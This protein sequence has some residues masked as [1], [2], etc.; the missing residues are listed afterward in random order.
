MWFF[1]PDLKQEALNNAPYIFPYFFDLK[2]I[3]LEWHGI[4]LT[5]STVEGPKLKMWAFCYFKAKDEILGLIN[6]WTY[7]KQFTEKLFCCFRRDDPDSTTIRFSLFS[8]ENL[9]PLEN[10]E[11]SAKEMKTNNLPWV[12]KGIYSEIS[13]SLEMEVGTNYFIFPEEYKQIDELSLFAAKEGIYP[14]QSPTAY[15]NNYVLVILKPKKDEVE[16]S[17]KIGL[18]SRALTL[19]MFGQ[20]ESPEAEETTNFTA[21]ELE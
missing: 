14:D 6:F 9:L 19:A 18:I 20:R 13:L 17:H 1:K 4:R 12:F 7:F 15:W 5:P 8:T 11:D 3:K 16:L 21:R 10:L 2:K